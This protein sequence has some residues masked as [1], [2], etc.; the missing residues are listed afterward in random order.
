MREDV[1]RE[2]STLPP[3]WVWTTLGQVAHLN[4]RIRLS[5]SVRIICSL[6]SAVARRQQQRCIGHGTSV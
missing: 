6:V 4:R 1:M 2:G 5:T 3:G